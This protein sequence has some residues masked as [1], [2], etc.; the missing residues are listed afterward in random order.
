MSKFKTILIASDHRGFALKEKL[1][2]YLEQKFFLKVD[3]LGTHCRDSCDY[4]LLAYSLAKEISKGRSARGILIC[5]S[6][7]GQSI[8]A[9]R[10]TR[11]RAA[12]CHNVKAARFSRQHNDSNILVL[13]SG[14]LNDSQAKRILGVW[15]NTKFLGGRHKRRLNQITKIEKE[16]MG[17]GR[18]NT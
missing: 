15:L 16:I 12:L 4:P 8:V 9:N 17:E 14:F 11:V 3:D 5:N 2:N 7:I 1:K 18:W 10:L 13:G 6:G